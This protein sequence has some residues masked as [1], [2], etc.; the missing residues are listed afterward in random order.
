M[1]SASVILVTKG[2][3]SY[4][5]RA[6]ASLLNAWNRFSHGE[7]KIQIIVVINGVDENAASYLEKAADDLKNAGCILKIVQQDLTNP[8]QARNNGFK[9]VSGDWCFFIDD[10]AYV[11]KEYFVRWSQTL[12]K[13]P[14]VRIIGGPNL[15]PETSTL[16][17]TLTGTVLSS[18]I[19]SYLS[20]RRYSTSGLPQPVNDQSLILCNL[21][22]KSDLLR[23]RDKIFNEKMECAEENLLLQ[24]LIKD[25][26]VAVRDPVLY[27]YHER[28]ST[29]NELGAQVYKYGRGRAQN[30]ISNPASLHWAH[31]LPSFCMIISGPLFVAFFLSQNALWLI[32]FILYGALTI[33]TAGFIALKMKKNIA[34]SF[35]LA[36]LLLVQIHVCFGAGIL[37]GLIVRRQSTARESHG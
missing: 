29:L 15:T 8:G 3:L 31:L 23:K 24:Q 20:Y 32:P 37:S 7:T 9:N 5:K 6:I 33:F 28:R 1:V 30:I 27:L 4:F 11:D 25:G 36:T 19:S 2:R 12:E 35:F 16:F 21:W 17:Q 13:F 10:D 34:H 18:P 22:I 26:E 14:N